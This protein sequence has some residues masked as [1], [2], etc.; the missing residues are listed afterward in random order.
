MT[1][2]TTLRG[3]LWPLC[4]FAGKTQIACSFTDALY[5]SGQRGLHIA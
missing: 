3:L 1:E 4:S 5:Q 2:T